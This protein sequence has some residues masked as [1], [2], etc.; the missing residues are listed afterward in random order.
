MVFKVMPEG[1][2]NVRGVLKATA[3]VKKSVDV[4]VIEAPNKTLPPPL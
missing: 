4:V 2:V 3:F 1:A